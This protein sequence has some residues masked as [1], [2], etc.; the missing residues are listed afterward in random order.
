MSLIIQNGALIDIIETELE[1][2]ICTFKF[3][4]SEKMDNTKH[5]VFKTKCPGC[6]SVIG[7]SIPIFGGTTEC[8]E[9][10]TSPVIKQLK[11]TAPFTINGKII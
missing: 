4:A 1:C 6:K 11:T 2:P 7:I 9:W 5:P 8:F 10:A 3:D